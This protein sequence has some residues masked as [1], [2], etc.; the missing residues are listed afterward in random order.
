MLP[1][2]IVGASAAQSRPFLYDSGPAPAQPG[3]SRLENRRVTFEPASPDPYHTNLSLSAA[4][5]SPHI[6]PG[7]A[8]LGIALF[9]ALS[10]FASSQPAR[11]RA[12][13]DRSSVSA[14]TNAALSSPV[15]V[16]PRDIIVR[17]Y[18][19]SSFSGAEV[20]WQPFADYRWPAPSILPEG[21]VLDWHRRLIRPESLVRLISTFS[22]LDATLALAIVEGVV[23][24]SP[25]PRTLAAATR[26]A[27]IGSILRVLQIFDIR[28][29]VW[30]AVPP[31]TSGPETAASVPGADGRKQQQHQQREAAFVPLKCVINVTDEGIS[32]PLDDISGHFIVPLHGSARSFAAV[33]RFAATDEASG[34]TVTK[35]ASVRGVI[36]VQGLSYFEVPDSAAPGTSAT[37]GGE[38]SRLRRWW[39]IPYSR[40]I[41]LYRR[42]QLQAGLADDRTQLQHRRRAIVLWLWEG[43]M[44]R[45]LLIYLADEEEADQFYE[46]VMHMHRL[47]QQQELQQS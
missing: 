22:A 47:W 29:T 10:T 24:P 43:G 18:D 36:S 7:A 17:Y 19:P 44:Q 9:P 34:R 35:T 1:H 6:M 23:P 38:T 26:T 8:R 3:S 20:T 40:M 33:Y 32:F 41:R 13:S 37:I 31:L 39:H 46:D 4:S 16:R 42:A 45:E 15:R 28:G 12:D 5:T 27:G 14:G 25:A 21:T 2:T 11:V 30:L